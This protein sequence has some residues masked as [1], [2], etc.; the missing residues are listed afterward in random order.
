M[1][2]V[3]VKD[4]SGQVVNNGNSA[5]F[6][7]GTFPRVESKSALQAVIPKNIVTIIIFMKLL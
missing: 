6:S 3:I 2:V 5:T 4:E 7:D 1:V